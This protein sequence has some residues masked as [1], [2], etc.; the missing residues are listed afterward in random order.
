[1][2][3]DDEMR[4]QITPLAK[5]YPKKTM[6]GKEQDAGYPSALGGATPTTTLQTSDN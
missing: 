5:P 6:R 1:M 3:L 4:K 2:P